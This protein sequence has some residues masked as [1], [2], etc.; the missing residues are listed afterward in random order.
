MTLMIKSNKNG[1]EIH[2]VKIDDGHIEVVTIKDGKNMTVKK[3]EDTFQGFKETVDAAQDTAELLG[4]LTS[5]N[6]DY[7]WAH[8]SGKL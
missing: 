5:L 2:S 8:V 7:I 3:L 6:Q 4:A 1:E